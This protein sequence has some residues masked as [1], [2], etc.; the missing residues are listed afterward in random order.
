L[1]VDAGAEAVAGAVAAS[2]GL[3]L[4]LAAPLV[5][6]AMLGQ[7]ALGLVARLAPNLQ[8][9]A[10]ASAGQ[11]LAG[12]L[13]MALILPTVVPIWAAAMGEAFLHPTEP[14]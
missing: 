7:V 3:A 9:Y 6:G 13:L 14:R 12:L 2:V 5:L 4:R 10:V 8:I 11:I 1:P